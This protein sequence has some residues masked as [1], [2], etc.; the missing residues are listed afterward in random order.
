MIP[1]RR[2]RN[3]FALLAAL[4]VTVG[5]SVMA[6]AGLLVARGV[7]SAARNRM[8]LTRGQWRAEDCL[9]RA[10]VAIDDALTARAPSAWGA[11]DRAVATSP[12]ITQAACDVSL[13]PT[14]MAI[15]VNAADAEHLLAPLRAIGIAESRAD[16]MADA[17]LDWRDT[18]DIPRPMGAE[19]DWYRTAG[20][21]PP[22][23]GPL[24]D[25][26]ESRRV[27]GFDETVV[28]DSVLYAVFTVE[29]GQ[30]SNGFP[31]AWILTARSGG[32][33]I[34][35]RLASGGNRAGIARRR[36]TP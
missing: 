10:R 24:A 11:L 27:R 4:W 3:G 15:D 2:N 7:V 12:V 5:L 34:E 13:V 29:P 25:L 9:A 32:A 26:R 22:R 1:P 23:N 36:T 28:S 20:R 19:R 6:L 16:S 31:D 17:L 30:A 33:T 18:D 14:G 35:L 21:F 8:T